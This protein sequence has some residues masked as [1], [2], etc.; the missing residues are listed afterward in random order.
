MKFNTNHLGYKLFSGKLK[1]NRVHSEQLGKFVAGL[2]DSDGSVYY[3]KD[4]DRRRLG[5]EITQSNNVDKDAT[6]LTA[7]RSFYDIGK[8][9]YKKNVNA[10]VWEMGVKDTKKFY[11]LIGKHLIVKKSH[12]EHLLSYYN[13]KHVDNIQELIDESRRVSCSMTHKKHISPAYLAGFICGDG[14]ICASFKVKPNGRIRNQLKI[15]ILLADMDREVLEAF[16]KDYG[17]KINIR[18]NGNVNWDLPLGKNSYKS[19]LKIKTIHPFLL[20]DYKY[21]N[22]QK[23]I[24]FHNKLQRLNE[25]DSKE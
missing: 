1:G 11:N 14:Y 21:D 20:L 15:S 6:L 10:H 7:L 2:F 19:F 25:T 8:I 24:N 18:K 22:F 12:F 13:N 9:R 23:I 4:G 3:R 5:C 16:Q 17:G